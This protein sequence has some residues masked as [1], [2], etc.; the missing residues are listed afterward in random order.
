M[1]RGEQPEN[2]CSLFYLVNFLNPCITLVPFSFCRT[3]ISQTHNIVKSFLALFALFL[4]P[5]RVPTQCMLLCCHLPHTSLSS[6]TLCS[7]VL[8]TLHCSVH[9]IVLLSLGCLQL[10]LCIL[11]TLSCCLLTFQLLSE[12]WFS[13]VS[14][15]FEFLIQALFDHQIL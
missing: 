6:T 1:T 3:I 11:D 13:V 8:L 14:A 9:P 7:F 2:P 5:V 10:F 4:Y 15:V 12:G